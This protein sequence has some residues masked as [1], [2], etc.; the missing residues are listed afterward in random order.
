MAGYVLAMVLNVVLPHVLA[1]VVMRRYM[2]GTVTAVLLNFPLGLLYLRQALS[3]HSIEL[4][5]FSWAGPLTVLVF[6]ASI[7]PLL[8]LGRKIHSALI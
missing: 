4:R 8:A 3:K 1:T 2:P 5:V 6:L 7:L